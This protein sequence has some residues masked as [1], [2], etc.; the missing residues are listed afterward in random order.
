M[1]ATEV[2]LPCP[3]CG[4]TITDWLE[5]PTPEAIEARIKHLARFHAS[6]EVKGKR[7][8]AVAG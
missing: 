2:H 1:T 5:K 8:S 4:E 3:V 7:R 6:Q